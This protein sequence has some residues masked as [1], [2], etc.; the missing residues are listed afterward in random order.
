[1]ARERTLDITQLWRAVRQA[2]G[3]DQYVHAQMVEHGYLIERR[4]TDG[5]SKRDLDAYKKTLK[6]EAAQRRKLRRDAWRAYKANNIVHIGDHVYW[7]DNDDWD[8]WDLEHAEKRC[9]ENELPQLDNP[10][11][12]AKALGIT[13]A[14]LRWLSYHREAATGIHYRRFEVA[15]RNG[16]P[17]PI[18]APMPMLKTVQRWILRQ[19]V[20]KLPVHGAAHGFLPGRSIATNAAEHTG[21]QIV[22]QMDVSQFF[23]TITLPRVRGVF[24]NAGYREQVATLLALLCTEAPREIVEHLDRTFYVATGPR[25]L[26]Q[27]APT[28]PAI[29]N[30]LCRRL[31]HRLAGLAARYQWRY[32]RY[33]DDLTFSLPAAHQ[34]GAHTAAMLGLARRIV[35]DE[36]FAVHPAKTRISRTGGQ[37]RVTGLVVNGAQPPRTPRKLRRQIRAAIHNLKA[38]RPLHEGETTST[39]AGYA[40]YINMTDPALA[41]RL[42]AALNEASGN[43]DGEQ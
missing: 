6:E 31:D 27:G 30:T 8:K 36:G 32:T 1:M 40:A 23:P 17:R 19:I 9:A 11:Q 14:Q 3:V 41:A 42:S 35:E 34:G 7:N 2:G 43:G 20:E 13:V 22:L 4:E 18:W 29:T 25:C 39:L 33:A 5:M 38:G 26:P 37:Q 10:Q 24:R 16:A 28:S 15:K 12:L 21:S